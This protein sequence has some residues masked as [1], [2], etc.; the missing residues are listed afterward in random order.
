MMLGRSAPIRLSDLGIIA[1]LIGLGILIATAPSQAGSQDQLCDV[2]ADYA[3][4]AEDYPRAIALHL[5]LLRS[6]SHNA[7]A[8]YHLGF[9][10]S[11]VGDSAKEVS[12]YTEAVRLGLDQWD[13]FMN[14]GLA[15]L[16]QEELGKAISALEIAVLLGP[17]HPET[18]FISRWLTKGITDYPP[19]YGRYRRRCGWH[20]TSQMSAI[21]ER[22]F[23]LNWVIRE[24]LAT[25]GCVCCK[26]H[27][28]TSPPELIWQFW[29]AQPC[30]RRNSHN[31]RRAGLCSRK[32]RRNRSADKV[33]RLLS[34]PCFLA[35]L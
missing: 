1:I 29:T 3:L 24:A 27:Q 35:E 9:A 32:L 21:R 31:V 20:R 11:M 7:L 33:N 30:P 16:D 12:E 22:S 5:K 17:G 19:H 23:T 10:Y 28:I 6:D 18:H 25:N 15:Y 34:R 4:R 8:H 2:R 14:L 13:L 26:S